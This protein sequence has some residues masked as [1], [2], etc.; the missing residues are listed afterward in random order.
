MN[1]CENAQDINRREGAGSSAVETPLP[2]P[3]MTKGF[4][5]SALQVSVLTS[6]PQGRE[7]TIPLLHLTVT[8]SHSIG[9]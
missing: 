3:V 9:N 6:T 7:A 5:Q 8:A 2:N 1:E 4:K